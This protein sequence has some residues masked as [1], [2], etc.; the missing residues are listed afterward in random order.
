MKL[1]PDVVTIQFL[2]GGFHANC[3]AQ[4][5]HTFLMGF[6]KFALSIVAF[7]KYL[8]SYLSLSKGVPVS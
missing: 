5:A 8:Y 1:K 6:Q 3:R 7:G 2:H 4:E